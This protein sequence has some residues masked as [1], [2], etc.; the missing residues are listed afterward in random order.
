MAKETFAPNATISDTTE[1]NAL[2]TDALI[3]TSC[4]PD[5]TKTNVLTTPNTPAQTPSNKNPYPLFKYPHQRLLKNHTSL[6]IDRAATPHYLMESKREDTRG[7]NLNGR[8]SKT[9]SI[10]V[11]PDNSR[12]WTKS[13]TRNSRTSLSLLTTRSN[14]MTLHMATSMESQVTLRI[15]KNFQW[16]FKCNKGVMLRF[17]FACNT[18]SHP[19]YSSFLSHQTIPI[20]TDY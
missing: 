9:T 3:V 15:S 10:E 2:S 4:D 17:S 12:Q 13:T 19:H 14:T 11:F 8:D 5:M 16:N 1:K 20:T 7:R 6:P 18:T